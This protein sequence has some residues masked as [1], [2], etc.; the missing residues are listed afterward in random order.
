MRWLSS[1]C[2]RGC[3]QRLR[4]S[5]CLRW[6]ILDACYNLPQTLGGHFNAP[7]AAACIIVD[8]RS[9]LGCLCLHTKPLPW[10]FPRPRRLLPLAGLLIPS[11]TSFWADGGILAALPFA[12]LLLPWTTSFWAD[13]GILDPGL[14]S[15]LSDS[16]LVLP[17]LA[18]RAPRPRCLFGGRD[19][20]A[21]PLR[22]HGRIC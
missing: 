6:E 10:I 15:D 18:L 1:R 8:F 4:C 11:A 7:T 3:A 19:L 14:E 16:V 22:H 9:Q 13:G 21:S 12:G 20:V 17:P 5:H 2:H